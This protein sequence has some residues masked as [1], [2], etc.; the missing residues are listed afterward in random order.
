[1]AVFEFVKQVFW[2]LLESPPPPQGKECFLSQDHKSQ[3]LKGKVDELE[4]VKL[5]ISAQ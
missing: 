4:H 1:M 5:K 2:F 3:T